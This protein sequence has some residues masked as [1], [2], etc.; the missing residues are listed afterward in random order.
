MTATDSVES[1]DLAIQN[2][3]RFRKAFNISFALSQKLFGAL[4]GFLNT[5]NVH[6]VHDISTIGK[7]TDVASINFDHSTGHSQKF[8]RSF[9]AD[10]GGTGNEDSN[11]RNM[12][13][14]HRDL[15]VQRG[16]RHGLYRSFEC[17]AVGC[18]D[19]ESEHEEKVNY[20]EAWR[21]SSMLPFM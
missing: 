6:G 2:T 16:K 17:R 19:I 5:G 11:E 15:S 3:L 1:G 7:H 21:T 12:M 8:L 9:L 20:L 13:L 10:D 18:E 4:L 14:K